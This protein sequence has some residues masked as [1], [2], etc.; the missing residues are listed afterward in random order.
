MTCDEC[1][2]ELCVVMLNCFSLA[3]R[4]K[5]KTNST[6]HI[7]DTIRTNTTEH[8]TITTTKKQ[9]QQQQRKQQP[10]TTHYTP[11]TTQLKHEARPRNKH[12]VQ[13]VARCSFS[14]VFS[15]ER[16]VFELF[17]RVFWLYALFLCEVLVVLYP[18][19]LTVCRLSVC[20]HGMS[21]IFVVICQL[22]V[23][24]MNVLKSQQV[25]VV[26]QWHSFVMLQNQIY[27]PGNK[28]QHQHRT[29]NNK[30]T[31]TLH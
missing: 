5:T 3:S 11:V 26:I 22:E 28:Q 21:L 1:A 7:G 24:C 30:H 10:A 19:Q 23:R 17:F 14:V 29:N 18:K 27:I 8:T 16:F 15:L 13:H 9:Q 25:Y 2:H 12:N 20:H 31:H 4:S 6:N